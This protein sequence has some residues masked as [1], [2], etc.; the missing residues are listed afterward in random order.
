MSE[1]DDPCGLPDVRRL[2]DI[3]TENGSYEQPVWRPLLP[4]IKGG[5]NP[6][7]DVKRSLVA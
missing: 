7:G 4:V 3:P 1:M 2:V 6:F 5:L